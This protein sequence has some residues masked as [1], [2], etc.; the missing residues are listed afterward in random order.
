MIV[1]DAGHGG[2][3]PGS[4]GN[5]I[6]EK[7][8]NLEISKYM[9]NRFREL[10]V[11]VQMTRTTDETL[12]P[13]ERVS[14]V[15]NAFGNNS[16]VIVLSNH[17]N[18]GGG[19]GAE[20]I[21]A[22]R[23]TSTLPNLILE[24]LEKEGQNI[25]KAYQRRLP[26]DTSKDYYFMQRETGNTQALTIEYGFLDTAA[27]AAQ[28]KNNWRDYSE[29]VVRAVMG[30]LKLPYIPPAGT[31]VYIVQPGDSLWSIA[32]K[33]NTTVDVLKATNNLTSN[34]LNVGQVLKIPKTQPEPVPPTPGEY[35]E[36]IVKSGDSLYSIAKKYN[37]TVNELMK[38]NN[39]TSNVL[40]I[41]QRIKIPTPGVTPPIETPSGEFIT[42]T[43]QPGDSL[44]A[45]AQRYN[46]TVNELMKVNN[47]TSNLLSIGQKLKIPVTAT[48]PSQPTTEY[49]QYTVQPGDNLYSI[50]QRYNTTTAEIM[51]INNLKS[52]LLSIGQVLKIPRGT[53]SQTTYVV[54]SGDNLYS[55]ANK[56]NTTVDE[57]KKKNNLKSNL[58]SIGQVLI[59]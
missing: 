2:E 46:T 55:I 22:L 10:G 36:Y 20:V 1:I 38:F 41:G 53:S 12:P 4:I 8:L 37:T 34:L 47:L 14:R 29:A 33:L 30:Y 18:A 16:N 52:N 27:D 44:Y 23:N 57:I 45:I 9:Y 17:I 3:D 40:S 6:I 50:A 25:R 59:I 54:K 5:G 11:P 28:L 31:D 19:D 56:F 39:L 35:T 15:L 43:V 26:S 51:Q 58:L 42:Y 24:E 49:I 21:Y 32:K 13:N 48:E 7:D